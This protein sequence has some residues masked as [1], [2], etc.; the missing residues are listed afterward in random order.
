MVH[1][2]VGFLQ[3]HYGETPIIY[4]FFGLHF[5][6][7]KAKKQK[8]SKGGHRKSASGSINLIKRSRKLKLSTPFCFFEFKTLHKN[9]K[10]TGDICSSNKTKKTC[11]YENY[12][13][14]NQR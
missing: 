11:Q 14:T 3:K 4:S 2:A 10:K 6:Q 5:L 12:I 8:P 13:F 1:I 9:K 7:Y